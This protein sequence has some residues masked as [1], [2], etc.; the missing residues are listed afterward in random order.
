[1]SHRKCVRNY[2]RW[3]CHM[4]LG[5]VLSGTTFN[6]F[7]LNLNWVFWNN[8]WRWNIF[9]GQ[10]MHKLV[11][12]SVWSSLHWFERILNVILP[13][14]SYIKIIG[15]FRRTID[16]ELTSYPDLL[17]LQLDQVH[18]LLVYHMTWANMQIKQ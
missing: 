15:M 11:W 3:N 5:F 8:T 13:L 2:Q 7:S 17:S 1:M 18:S 6:L 10:Q 12:E 4:V 16:T 14:F 9:Q